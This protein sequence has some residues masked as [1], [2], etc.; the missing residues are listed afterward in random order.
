M[1]IRKLIQ[2]NLLRNSIAA[3]FAAIEIHNK[4]QI[5]YRYETVSLLIVNAWE[6]LLKAYIRKYIKHRSI[7]VDGKY[8]IGLSKALEYVSDHINSVTP[9]R[10]I[11]IRDNLI[12]IDNYR[13]DIVHFYNESLKPC[14]FALIARSALNYVDFVKEHFGKDIIGDEGLFILPLG[15]KLPFKPE[16][17]LSK[18][19]VSAVAS[20][21]TKQF[22]ENVVKNILDLKNAGIEDSIVLGFNVYWESVKKVT[23]SDLVAAITSEEKADVCVNSRKQIYLTNNP[24]AQHVFLSD[25]EIKRLFPYT[26]NEL[27]ALCKK[28]IKNFKQ[29][30]AFGS[31][32]RQIKKNPDLC[33]ERKFYPGNPKSG[34]TYFYKKAALDEIRKQSH[35]GQK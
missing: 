21:E 22:I 6:L 19:A 3:Y 23:N 9:G 17:F 32:L 18:K 35:S 16:D 25:A 1:A 24:N 31:I 28:E 13:D 29:D 7:F 10:F 4:P 33:H 11:A 26:Y 12:Q 8:T 34:K 15:F 2:K 20:E 27:C 5:S 30:Q 14:V